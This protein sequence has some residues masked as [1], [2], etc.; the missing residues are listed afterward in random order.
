MDDRPHRL[1][2]R[3][4][5]C[6]AAGVFLLLIPL[7]LFSFYQSWTHKPESACTA[8][9]TDSVCL[10]SEP[11]VELPAETPIA[12]SSLLEDPSREEIVFLPMNPLFRRK[13]SALQRAD[14]IFSVQF[15]RKG[16]IPV[17]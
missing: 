13:R 2:K 9:Q 6:L 7:A 8:V 3:Q 11:V 4:F 15:H 12:L 10:F 17:R 5:F 14:P 1:E 16:R